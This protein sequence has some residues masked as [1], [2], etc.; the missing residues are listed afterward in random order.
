[1]ALTL[2][3]VFDNIKVENTAIV[4]IFH[5]VMTPPTRVQAPS[6]KRNSLSYV[7]FDVFLGS[8]AYAL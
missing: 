7:A 2:E 3:P 8:P 6:K 5:P 4:V 1:V